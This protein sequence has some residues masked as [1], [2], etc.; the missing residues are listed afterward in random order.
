MLK[1]RMEYNKQNKKDKKHNQFSKKVER[2]EPQ[3]ILRKKEK[4]ELYNLLKIKIYY[5]NEFCTY[6]LLP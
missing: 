6:F 4:C 2:R 1:T 3:K 5:D